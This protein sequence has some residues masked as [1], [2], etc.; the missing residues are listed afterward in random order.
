MKKLFYCFIVIFVYCLLSCY[1][2]CHF[3]SATKDAQRTTPSTTKKIRN[4]HFRER[5]SYSAEALWII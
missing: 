1:C 3:L 2:P 4:W 5:W